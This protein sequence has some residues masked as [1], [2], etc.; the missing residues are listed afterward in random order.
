M[1]EFCNKAIKYAI[2]DKTFFVDELL[3][4]N[5]TLWGITFYRALSI[6]KHVII[7]DCLIINGKS[8]NKKPEGDVDENDP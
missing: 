1:L 3:I 2:K 5:E 7:K 4:E 8:T 6:F